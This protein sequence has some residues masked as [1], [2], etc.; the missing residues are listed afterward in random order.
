MEDQIVR[1]PGLYAMWTV[2]YIINLVCLCVDPTEGNARNFNL[3]TSLLAHVYLVVSAWNNIFGTMMPSTFLTIAGSLHQYSFWLLMAYYQGDVY[4]DFN[5]VGISNVIH[6][7]TVAIFSVSM[8][9]S[10]W[11][12]TMYPNI[13]REYVERWSTKTKQTDTIVQRDSIIN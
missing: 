10:T 2:L 9:F 3:I 4:A 12:I 5:A 13:Y 1:G 6:T 7:V 8:L 11:G